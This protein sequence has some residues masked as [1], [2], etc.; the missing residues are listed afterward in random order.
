M[1]L[2]AKQNICIICIYLYIFIYILIIIINQ[3]LLNTMN[4]ILRIIIPCHLD[5]IVS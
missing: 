2:P 3:I 5:E 4:K 1:S